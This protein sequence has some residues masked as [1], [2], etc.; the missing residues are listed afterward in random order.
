MF[1]SQTIPT[2]L[3]QFCNIINMNLKQTLAYSTWSVF[4]NYTFVFLIRK[5]WHLQH[6]FNKYFWYSSN[7]A[8]FKKCNQNEKKNV[9][10]YS[11]LEK[12]L[13]SHYSLLWLLLSHFFTFSFASLC[14]S[15]VQM[16]LFW[17]HGGLRQCQKLDPLSPVPE[18][19]NRVPVWCH[20]KAE[21]TIT[22][23]VM[24]LLT[25]LALIWRKTRRSKKTTTKQMEKRSIFREKQI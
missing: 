3:L 5:G 6:S 14:H 19:F 20:D 21:C 23:S 11:A 25:Y 18:Y 22:S 8:W 4:I 1:V 24:G 12:F 2:G 7:R 10:E 16:Q 9:F 17:K 15:G 13:M